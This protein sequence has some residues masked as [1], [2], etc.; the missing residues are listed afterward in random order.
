MN[1]LAHIR[2]LF[3]L[4]KSSG[5]NLHYTSDQTVVEIVSVT[6]QPVVKFRIAYPDGRTY[7]REASPVWFDE[8]LGGR[9]AERLDLDAVVDADVKEVITEALDRKAKWDARLKEVS[10]E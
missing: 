10:G 1:V 7:M 6:M 9:L 5:A 2:K 3:E 8:F 4:A